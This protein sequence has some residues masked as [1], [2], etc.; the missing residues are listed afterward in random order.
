MFQNW[1]LYTNV[2][3]NS[4]QCADLN[5]AIA[6]HMQIVIVWGVSRMVQASESILL[7]E[8]SSCMGHV[9]YHKLLHAWLFVY[10]STLTHWPLWGLK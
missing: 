4:F 7:S 8:V 5:P 6:D 2:E 3:H 10:S 9:M 1:T